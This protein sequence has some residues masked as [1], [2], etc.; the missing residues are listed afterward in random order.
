[1]KEEIADLSPEKDPKIE[2]MRL[3][4]ASFHSTKEFV[5][6]FRDRKLPLHLLINNAGVFYPTYGRSTNTRRLA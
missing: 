3:D 4:L 2:F 1:M 6:A 5:S